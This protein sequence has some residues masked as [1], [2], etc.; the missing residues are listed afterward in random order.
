MNQNLDIFFLQDHFAG[1]VSAVSALL[2]CGAA[3]ADGR[4]QKRKD[5]NKVGFMPWTI[6]T[7]LAGTLSF[8][9]LAYAIRP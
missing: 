2:A 1:L 4:R 3:F 9:F 7:V 6:L 8:A 5:L